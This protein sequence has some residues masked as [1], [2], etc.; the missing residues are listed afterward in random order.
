MNNED[1]KILYKSIKLTQSDCPNEHGLESDEE[2]HRCDIECGDCWERAL[3]VEMER[4]D[5]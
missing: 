5:I 3:S 4:R 2:N 1:L